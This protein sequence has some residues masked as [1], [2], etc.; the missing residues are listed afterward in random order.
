L[1]F[2]A[3]LG[4]VVGFVVIVR[5]VLFLRSS[6]R[7]PEELVVWL[8]VGVAL[9]F[10]SLFPGSIGE[11]ANLFGVQEPVSLFLAIGVLFLLLVS[12]WLYGMVMD[13]KRKI[14]ILHDYVSLNSLRIQERESEENNQP[15]NDR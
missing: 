14:G 6:K 4:L 1:S 10:F 3:F 13:L 11:Y 7:T 12:F 9:V 8:T 15:N 5:G 2:L